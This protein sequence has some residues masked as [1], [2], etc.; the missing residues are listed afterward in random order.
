VIVR[1]QESEALV[2][3]ELLGETKRLLEPLWFDR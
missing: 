3:D 1:H 2:P